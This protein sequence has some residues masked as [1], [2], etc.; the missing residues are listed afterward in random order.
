MLLESAKLYQSDIAE[1]IVVDP[2]RATIIIIVVSSVNGDTRTYTITVNRAEA[3][4][5][6][7]DWSS[8]N[9]NA[10]TVNSRGLVERI[11]PGLAQITATTEDSNCVS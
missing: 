9:S 5:K 2:G 11:A 3:T 7:V 1:I 10:A 8:D 4:N 6:N